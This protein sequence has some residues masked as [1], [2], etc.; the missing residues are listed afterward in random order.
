M[1]QATRTITWIIFIL[2]GI[3]GSYKILDG[4]EIRQDRT[5]KNRL[6][7]GKVL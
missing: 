7:M 3:K 5:R 2:V 4:F 1:I 6:T